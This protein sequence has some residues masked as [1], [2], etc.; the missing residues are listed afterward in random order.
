[1]EPRTAAPALRFG[2]L[3][4]GALAAYY[5]PGIRRG[6]APAS[7]FTKL[8]EEELKSADK[9]GFRDDDG[10]WNEAGELG[11]AML[12][13]YIDHYGKDDEWEILATEHPFRVVVKRQV[14][15]GRLESPWFEMV[16]VIDGLWRHRPT[17]RVHVP[18]HKTIDALGGTDAHP[19]IPAWLL[20]DDQA[21]TYWSYGVEGLI[22][23]K[24][25]K[26]NERLAGM[27]FNFLVKKMPDERPHKLVKGQRLYLN[28]DGAISK[29]QPTPHFARIPIL[30]DEYD[31]EMSKQRTSDD[32]ARI[33]LVRDGQLTPLKTP[34]RF[35]C[36]MCPVKDAC[37][38]HETG[39]DWEGM[40]EQ[41]M[42]EWDPYAQ[43]EILEGR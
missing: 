5:K 43:H 28:K 33:E 32:Y 1:M 18:D 10:T 36:P 41:T 27:L 20:M 22:A 30:R 34:G 37:E 15:N 12:E 24:L 7:T 9:M 19:K 26:E 29:K 8:Y 4:H 23:Q 35:T 17:R 38:L 16:G 25:M 13:N 3:V 21:G 11:V 2:T 40:L 6:P 14:A 42:R 31:R 39:S